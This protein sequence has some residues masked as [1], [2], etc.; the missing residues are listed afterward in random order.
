MLLLIDIAAYLV[1]VP[2]GAMAALVGVELLVGSGFKRR[3]TLL[4]ADEPSIAVLIPAHNEAEVIAQTL[5]SVK[6]CLGPNDRLLVVADNCSD[7][8]A[9]I[10]RTAGAD[11]AERSNNR[12]RGKGFALD[13][14]VKILAEDPPG[15]V[16]IL[17]ADCVVTQNALD[18][19]RQS[20]A[21]SDR[22]VQ[23]LYLIVQ[24]SKN[25]LSIKQKLDAFTFHLK[26]RVRAAGLQAMG[27]PVHM[28]GSGVALKWEHLDGLAL[29]TSNIVED[30]EIGLK[31][32][33][34]GRGLQ[35][36][37]RARVTSWFPETGTGAETQ[38]NRWVHG[39]M[40][41]AL[42]AAPK[43]L[44]DSL[45]RGR[46]GGA[47]F[48]LDAMVP[49]LTLF[50]AL[51]VAAFLGLLTLSLLSGASYGPVLWL[52]VTGLIL[53]AGLFTALAK[54]EDGMLS[55]SDIVG[56]GGYVIRSVGRAL[57]GAFKPEKTWIRTDRSQSD[58][59]PSDRSNQS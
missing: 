7:D 22:P 4:K 55:L 42:F 11:V 47:L 49:P 33:A 13:H 6:A 37:D 10:A 57:K 51:L 50:L 54:A 31:L 44:F 1:G 41:V 40:Q 8:T 14:G 19:A 29:A 35:Y 2:L 36:E 38:K 27:A 30:M 46:V 15:A 58:D 23:L 3:D 45:A 56:A 52:F 17:D 24:K 21:K 20:L 39:H 25:G 48:A 5:E 43:A 59:P 16:M 26:N 9:Q 18:V 34:L 12:E 28:S 32:A 53:K